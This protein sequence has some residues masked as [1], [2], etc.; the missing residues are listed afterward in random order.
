MQQRKWRHLQRSAADAGPGPSQVGNVLRKLG[1][2]GV[3][4]V[5]AQYEA[6]ALGLCQR[7][8]SRAQFIALLH[9]N[10]LRN[11]HMIVLRQENQKP[12]GDADLRR[13]PGALA[14]NRILDHLHRQRL[15]L[16]YLLLNRQRRLR[17]AHCRRRLALGLSLPD[18]GHVQ[19]GSAVKPYVDEGRLHTR[20]HPGDLAEVDIADQPALERALDM[21]LL[22]DAILDQRHPGLL[23]RP[24]DQ[25]VVLHRVR[26]LSG[27]FRPARRRRATAR[28]FRTG[29]AP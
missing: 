1:I 11:A 3:F 27:G 7:L 12:P 17:R 28:R 24:V 20:K 18:V 14:A 29:A 21:Q 23:R 25:N 26:L 15:P 2:V 13:Q 19:E 10:F 16:E 4:A 6:A 9:R 22:N 8:Q 5:G